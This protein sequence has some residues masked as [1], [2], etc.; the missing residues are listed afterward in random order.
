[1]FI[2]ADGAP[3][4]YHPANSGLDDLANAGDGGRWW[5]VA[6]DENGAP[7][8]QGPSDPFPGYYVST[9]A[10]ADWTKRPSDPAR[11]VD[12]SKI[13][14]VVLPREVARQ[15]GA[16][17]GDFAAVFNLRNGK[18]SP[19]IFADI[20]PADSIGE[21]SVALADRLGV[22]SSPRRGGAAGGIFYILFPASG[23]GRPRTLEEIETEGDKLLRD[24]GGPTRVAACT[25]N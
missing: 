15:V 3:N 21:G 11:Y 20:G 22:R 2:D 1:M 16:R 7:Y 18:S 5:G 25:S 4:A 24:W 23:N 12:A 13:P 6:K 19:A 10:L 9:T 8:V 17:L 14:Y